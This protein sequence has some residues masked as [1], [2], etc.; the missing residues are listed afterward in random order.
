M[1][2]A[3][4]RRQQPRAGNAARRTE[5]QQLYRDMDDGCAASGNRGGAGEAHSLSYPPLND[6][7]TLAEVPSAVLSF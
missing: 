2:S 1:R 3:S 5:R 6:R 4:S 7:R